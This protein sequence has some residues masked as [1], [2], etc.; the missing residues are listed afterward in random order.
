MSDKLTVEGER[1]FANQP[2][3]GISVGR[4]ILRMSSRLWMSGLWPSLS[5]CSNLWSSKINKAYNAPVH[6]KNPLAHHADRWHAVECVGKQ[7][8]CLHIVSSLACFEW[9]KSVIR[10]RSYS[11]GRGDSHS[12]MKPYFWCKALAASQCAN[13]ASDLLHLHLRSRGFP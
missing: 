6:A 2:L 12:S 1:S 8:P 7:F 5:A 3:S 11:A 13:H 4:T 10:K 9:I